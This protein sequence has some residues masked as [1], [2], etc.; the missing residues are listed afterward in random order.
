[1]RIKVSYKHGDLSHFMHSQSEWAWFR[2]SPA[3][4]IDI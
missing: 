4:R 3:V 1:M 2:L